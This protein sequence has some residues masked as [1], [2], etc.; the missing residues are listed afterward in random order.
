ML[1]YALQILR[2]MPNVHFAACS[3]FSLRRD[4]AGSEIGQSQSSI[5]ASKHGYPG[6]W[7]AL[8]SLLVA[9]GLFID[10]SRF[11]GCLHKSF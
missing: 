10:Q 2:F 6:V 9:V 8:G 1:S 4:I 11:Q 7:S 3:D 5:A